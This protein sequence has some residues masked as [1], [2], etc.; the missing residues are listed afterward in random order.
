MITYPIRLAT[1]ERFD[2]Y[3]FTNISGATIERQ[4][5]IP[6]GVQFSL[7][8]PSNASVHHIWI[9][10]GAFLQDATVQWYVQG[11]LT[12]FQNSNEVGRFLLGDASKTL[13]LAQRANAPRRVL[14]LSA[15]GLGS[16]MPVLR[17]QESNTAVERNNLDM[18]ATT[19]LC[20]CDEIK[21]LIERSYY[22]VPNL[23][24]LA[25]LIGARVVSMN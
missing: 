23:N 3:D 21:F 7:I 20:R 5:P 14:R 25:M 6:P 4:N 22:N 19:L 8:V 2:R 12:F 18:S 16:S 15:D 17:Y 11:A 9:G 10:S 13:S 24:S 1:S